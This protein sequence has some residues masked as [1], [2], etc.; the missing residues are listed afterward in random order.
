MTRPKIPGLI[1]KHLS[2]ILKLLHAFD[3]TSEFDIFCFG[4]RADGTF[5]ASSDLDVLLK[6]RSGA[7]IPLEKLSRLKELFEDSDLPFKVDVLDEL[8]I[9]KEFKRKIEKTLV[10]IR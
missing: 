8:A 2:E 6:A 7:K 10:K 5:R 4:S 9:S 1:N 3:P